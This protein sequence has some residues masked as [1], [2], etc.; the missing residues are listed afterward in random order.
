[1]AK[2]RFVLLCLLLTCM[3]SATGQAGV[4]QQRQTANGTVEFT[5]VPR[6]GSQ[7]ASP[8]T[9]APMATKATRLASASRG[10][11]AFWFRERPDGVMEFTNLHPVGS[12][13]KVLFRTGPGKASS[14]RGA[15]DRI[16]A[17]DRSVE[18][19]SR[20]DEHI[21]DQQMLYG[22][23]P[24]LARAVIRSESDFDPRV[25][26][27]AG[28][29]GLMQ[30]MPGTARDMG[31]TD[32]FDPRQNIMGGCRYLQILARKFCRTPSS[33]R[34]GVL[35]HC[36]PEEN[37][38]VIS[39]YHAGPGAVDKYGGMPP[40]QTTREYVA[41]VLARFDRYV[42]EERSRTGASSEAPWE[43]TP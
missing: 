27:S 30:L 43:A 20:F 29:M 10:S 9:A 3:A 24:S 5:N 32:P 11:G 14:V 18:R 25:V 17:S 41:T 40:Y 8:S 22:I 28:A 23:P 42:T 1:M 2:L 38:K 34:P 12:K 13:W 31:V 21:R 16:A 33:G 37:I 15:T 36:S 35:F 4:W 7:L 39:G 6:G 19:F 26:S